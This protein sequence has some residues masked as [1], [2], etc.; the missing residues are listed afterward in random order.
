MQEGRLMLKEG[1]NEEKKKISRESL[2]EVHQK[3]FDDG[4]KSC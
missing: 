1:R 2:Y 3:Q 4:G